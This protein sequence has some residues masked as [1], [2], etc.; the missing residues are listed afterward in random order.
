LPTQKPTH[1]KIKELALPH[2]HP[3]EMKIKFSMAE[4]Q[5]VYYICHSMTSLNIQVK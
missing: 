2:H 3:T 1:K 5:N 4:S